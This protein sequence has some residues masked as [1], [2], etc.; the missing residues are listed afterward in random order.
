MYPISHPITLRRERLDSIPIVNGIGSKHLEDSEMNLFE[1]EQSRER[2]RSRTEDGIIFG[3]H[4]VDIET[5]SRSP[6]AKK[7]KREVGKME[8]W[9]ESNV[10]KEL[11]TVTIVINKLISNAAKNKVKEIIDCYNPLIRE[12]TDMLKEH[13][14]SCCNDWDDNLDVLKEAIRHVWPEIDIEY[15]H[16]EEINKLVDILLM[17][18]ETLMPKQ[19]KECNLY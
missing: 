4:V 13:M 1:V 14:I 15:E 3:T 6:E 12:E 5:N 2:K 10:D 18:I 17:A 8:S 16:S 11:I 9:K 7:G 19:C